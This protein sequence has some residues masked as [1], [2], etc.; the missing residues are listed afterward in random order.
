[1]KLRSYLALTVMMLLASAVPSFA[2]V[3]PTD[4]FRFNM[5]GVTLAVVNGYRY[6]LELDA[7]LQA[8]PLVVTC[9]NPV[10]PFA[11]TAVIPAITPTSHTARVRAVDTSGTTLLLGDWSDLLSFTMR[12]TPSKPTGFT[13]VPGG[14]GS[15]DALVFDLGELPAP[16]GQRR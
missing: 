4:K 1:M 3:A 11:C 5:P 14:S 6:D 12:A 13:I 2:Q 8:V 16:D 10:E 9:V 15:G 7:V